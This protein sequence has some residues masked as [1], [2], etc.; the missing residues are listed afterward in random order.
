VTEQLEQ[1]IREEEQIQKRALLAA[2][3][4]QKAQQADSSGYSSMKNSAIYNLE[5][6]MPTKEYMEFHKKIQEEEERR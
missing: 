6:I 3:R 5:V 2:I 1:E 4:T